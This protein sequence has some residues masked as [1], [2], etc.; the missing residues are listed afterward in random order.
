[1][2]CV[3]LL[4]LS[5]MSQVSPQIW[6]NGEPCMAASR[7]LMNQVSPYIRREDRTVCGCS[8]VNRH[9][10]DGDGP[11]QTVPSPPP[12]SPRQRIILE[13]R[14]CDVSGLQREN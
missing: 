6:A 2:K 9:T 1:M 12:S 10:L 8:R 14:A 7:V 4:A 5:F 13:H 3:C 11:R